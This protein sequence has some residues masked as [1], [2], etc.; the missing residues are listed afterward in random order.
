MKELPD[1]L[2]SHA[3]Q[4]V[5]YHYLQLLAQRTA[6]LERQLASRP[7]E[8][9]PDPAWRENRDAAALERPETAD[10]RLSAIAPGFRRLTTAD[11]LNLLP[12][13]FEGFWNAIQ[14]EDLAMMASRL[15]LPSLDRRNFE[16]S[17]E[18]V[19][20]EARCLGALARDE[21]AALI[22]FCSEL[23]STLKVRRE[24][25]LVDLSFSALRGQR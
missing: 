7:A 22:R 20:A 17:K 21:L 5:L 24:M 25:D 23:P 13:I 16:P 9:A 6:Q 12:V 2:R 19:A 4:E 18:V 3:E 10:A 14:F 11:V 8:R 1:F 15:G